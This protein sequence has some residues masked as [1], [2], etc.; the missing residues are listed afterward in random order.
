MI[1]L[2]CL[3]GLSGCSYG[4]DVRAVMIEGRLAFVADGAT[5]GQA[6]C[7]SHIQVLPE[8][9]PAGR[10][11]ESTEAWAER[12][13]AWNDYGGY[14]CDD[15]FPIFYGAPLKGQDEARWRDVVAKPLRVGVTYDVSA[16]AGA[17]GYGGGQFRLLPDGGVENLR[18]D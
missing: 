8:D 9:Y 5:R 3:L 16:V 4:F 7:V 10:D 14:D 17:T 6:K 12:A 15:R 18:R 1:T 11:G 13:Y 2:V